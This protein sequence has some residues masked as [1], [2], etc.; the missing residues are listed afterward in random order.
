MKLIYSDFKK[1]EAKVKIENLDDLWYLSTIIDSNDEIKGRTLRKIRIGEKDQR[2]VN[3]LKKAVFLKIKAEKIEFS[4][5]SNILRV[6]GQITEAPEDVPKGS[7]H[8]F[9]LEVNSIITITKE[10]WLG[11]QLDKLKE[12][13]STKIANILICVH[14]REEAYFALMKKYGYELLSNIK[15]NVA[16]KG[17]EEK[18]S[19]NFYLEIINQIREYVERYNIQTIIIASPAFWKEELMKN[20]KDEELKKKT[21]L[22]TCSS[23]GKNGIDEVLKREETKKALENDRIAKEVNLVEKLMMEISKNNL[24]VYGLKDTENAV[25]AGAVDVLLVTDSLIQKTRQEGNYE[26][27]DGLIKDAD[28]MRGHVCIVSSDHE[29]GKRLNG[30]GGIAALLRYK[31]NY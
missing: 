7:Y 26:K 9:N 28:K 31:L 17:I 25:D 24:A 18:T 3:I 22:C 4:K 10:K 5:T 27:I 29:G 30:L 8:T 1:G 23:V 13:S 6:S 21:I 14:D 15:G 20:L 16:K 11:F 19:S 12:A 2:S